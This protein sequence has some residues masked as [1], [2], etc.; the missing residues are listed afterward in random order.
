MRLKVFS[1]GGARGNPGP[2]AIGFLVYKMSP[3]DDVLLVKK[4]EYIGVSTNNKAEYTA[5]FKALSWILDRFKSKNID[6]IICFLDSQLVCHQLNGLYRVKDKDLQSL[7]D[8]I[9]SLEERLQADISYNH[10][11]RSRNKEADLLVNLALDS[12]NI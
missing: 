3:K 6:E 1:D 9:K 12:A 10:I 7:V 8:K 11:Q 2:A 5:L 4:N